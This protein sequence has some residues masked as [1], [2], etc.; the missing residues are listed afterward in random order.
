M[1]VCRPSRSM[2]TRV[3]SSQPSRAASRRSSPGSRRRCAATSRAVASTA[4]PSGFRGST[5]RAAVAT[6]AAHRTIAAAAGK[7]ALGRSD[8][9]RPRRNSTACPRVRVGPPKR[10]SGS[11]PKSSSASTVSSAAS[12]S[13]AMR[14]GA[15]VDQNAQNPAPSMT[16]CGRPSSCCSAHT[17]SAPSG[18]WPA[19]TSSRGRSAAAASEPRA[20]GNPADHRR[21][22][23]SAAVTPS[24]RLP[25]ARVL[26]GSARTS[27][28]SSRHTRVVVR[29]GL[30]GWYRRRTPGTSPGGTRPG[31]CRSRYRSANSRSNSS[32]QS[33][34]ARR[35]VS[36]G[37]CR[38]QARAQSAGTGAQAAAKRASATRT[39]TGVGPSPCGGAAAGSARRP[40]LARGAASSSRRLSSVRRRV[41]PPP[42]SPA[43]CTPYRTRNRRTSVVIARSSPRTAG[44]WPA[45][46]ST[47]RSNPKQNSRTK[48][49]GTSPRRPP[50]SQ[51]RYTPRVLGGSR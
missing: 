3:V 43:R 33:T 17:R 35:L 8:A 31:P 23:S 2:S 6:A 7:R 46:R 28:R 21:Y 38:T 42:T 20:W 45:S 1:V 12:S 25:S 41:G 5:G 26:R 50:A 22:G 11:T 4:S 14:S 24:T 27:G 15:A 48:P 32:G 9:G 13:R 40:G 37:W 10:T 49:A 44:S 30:A 19:S 16:A 29:V 47:R 39:P 51:S 36:D 34:S 18:P